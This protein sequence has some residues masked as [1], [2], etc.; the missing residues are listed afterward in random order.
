MGNLNVFAAL[1]QLPD[2]S[3]MKYRFY[4]VKSGI[5]LIEVD[6]N[7]DL[8]H[9]F[10]RAQEFYESVNPKIQGHKFTFEQ[11]KTWYESQSEDGTFSYGEDWIGF[12]LPSHAI[13][14]CY[15]I[16]TERTMYDERFLNFSNLCSVMSQAQG[17]DSYYLLGVRKGDTQTLDHELAHGLFTV[18][19][20]YRQETQMHI[21]LMSDE[22]K[23]YL[24]NW[25][26][27]KGY[28]A[29]VH[30]DE[31][32]AFLSTGLHSTMDAQWLSKDVEVFRKI[33][34]RYNSQGVNMNVVV[35]TMDEDGPQF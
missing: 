21:A 7:E 29:S 27:K 3:E 1:F 30:N 25:L 11:Y 9:M 22:K 28:A 6:G 18:N 23:N 33:F 13:E 32:Q 5:F 26:T 15:T 14:A 12:N 2:S 8:G 4:E 31:I 17:M 35:T 34:E 16:N 20:D 24:Y 10:L 19:K